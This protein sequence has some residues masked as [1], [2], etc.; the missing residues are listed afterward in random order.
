MHALY[1]KR[2]PA[3]HSRRTTFGNV[4]GT[5]HGLHK[6]SFRYRVK[7][8]VAYWPVS[9]CYGSIWALTGP[10]LHVR[11]FSDLQ[12]IIN[13]NAEIAHGALQLSMP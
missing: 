7:A 11:L 10:V 13:L 3:L 2:L 5:P 1:H 12:R 6:S 8:T 4:G 9:A